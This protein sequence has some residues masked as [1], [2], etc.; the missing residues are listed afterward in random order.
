VEHISFVL[1]IDPNREEEYIERHK[2]VYPELEEAFGR[3]GIHRY[4]IYF[5]EGILFAYMLVDNFETAM[6]QLEHH[7]ANINWQ[8][9]MEDM[10]IPW[11]HGAKIKVIR[12]AYRYVKQG[13]LT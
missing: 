7:R 8:Q 1:R 6:E 10:L 2:R 4:H 9:Y 13:E 5:H 3:A 11:D 12:E